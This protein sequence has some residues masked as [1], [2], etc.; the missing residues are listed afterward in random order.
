MMMGMVMGPRLTHRAEIRHE[1]RLNSQVVLEHM[2]AKRMELVQA[3]HDETYQTK[4]QCPA[5]M[6]EL[7]AAEILKGFNADPA[8]FTT[9]CP[10][11]GERFSPSLV[12]FGPASRLE[13]PFYCSSQ[14]LDQMHGLH[15]LPPEEFARQHP[16]VYRSAIAHHGSISSA[17][18]ILGVA[19]HFEDISGWEGKV[20]S[21][22]GKLPDTVIA[23]C[24][25]KSQYV[26]RRMRHKYGIPAFS[27]RRMMEKEGEIGS[28]DEEEIDVPEET[29]EEEI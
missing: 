18:A 20:A 17:F 12:C 11:C 26:I 6:R 8:D 28:Q 23:Q 2:F 9:G 25:N 16:A 13:L 7:T 4:A 22:M 3:L 29:D 5:C 19:Y 10:K 15:T 1:I 21:F 24:V 27:K 14:V